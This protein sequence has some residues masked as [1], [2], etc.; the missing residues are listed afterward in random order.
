VLEDGRV[1]RAVFGRRLLHAGAEWRYWLPPV[2][3]VARIAP[4]IFVDTARAFE[5]GTFSDLRAHLDIGAGIRFVIPGAGVAGIDVGQGL[6]DG[7]TV[8][9]FGWRK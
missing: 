6:R 3:R 7:R 5:G 4:A 2:K 8:V 1:D 9:S